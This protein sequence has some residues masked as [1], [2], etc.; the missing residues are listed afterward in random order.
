MKLPPGTTL[1]DRYTVVEL[2]GNGAVGIVYRVDDLKR[3]CQVALKVLRAEVASNSVATERFMREVKLMRAIQ[4]HG[5]VTIFD[6]GKMGKAL[7]YT[8]ELVEGESIKARLARKGPMGV[9]EARALMQGVC[10]VME[11]VHRVAIH[12]DL[13][14]DNIMIRPDASICL[15]DFGTALDTE[16]DSDLTATGVHLGKAYYSPPEQY[17]DSSKLDTR[18]DLYSMG[19]LFY[20]M[21]SKKLIVEFEPITKHRPDLADAFNPFFEK[22]LAH[23]PAARFQTVQEFLTAVNNLPISVIRPA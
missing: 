4:H 12:R 16:F 6:T 23:D 20:E 13:S 18:A 3:E 14:S 1:G 2:L 5:I 8:M 11:E 17:A 7:F 15:L 10:A 22:A 19:M 21:V 9:G